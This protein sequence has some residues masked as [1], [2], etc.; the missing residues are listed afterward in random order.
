[1]ELERELA[2]VLNG[3]V[4][5]GGMGVLLVVVLKWLVGD[6]FSKAGKIREAELKAFDVRLT[7]LRNIAGELRVE[8]KHV[9]DK[10][11]HSEMAILKAS[12]QIRHHG[13]KF[14]QQSEN[15]KGLAEAMKGFVQA[16]NER[17]NYIE[18][19]T[20]KVIVKVGEITR[21]KKTGNE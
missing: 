12:E 6:Y 13:E 10:L 14:S 7:D 5:A 16:A 17:M 4:S 11:L 19:K 3:M 1:M 18:S 2:A 8:V 9:N 21:I 15:I 20:D